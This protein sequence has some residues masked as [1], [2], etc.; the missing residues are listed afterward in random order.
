MKQGPPSS[1]DIP[2]VLIVD[3][4]IANLELL[5]G[6]LRERGINPRPVPNGRLALRSARVN[7]PDLILLDIDMPEMNGYEVCGHLKADTALKDIPVIFITAFSEVSDKVK[8]FSM[9]AVDYV[10][11]P[12]Q[13]DEVHARVE[14]HLRLRKL[15]NR[16]EWQNLHLAGLVREQVAEISIAQLATIVALAKLTEYR[17]DDTGYHIERTQAFCRI[18]AA[19]LRTDHRHAGGIDEA[20]VENIAVAAPLHDIGKVGISDNILLKPGKLTPEEF[21]IMKTHTLIGA[22]TLQ[23][24]QSKYEGNGFLN[25]GILIARSHHE[26][27]D[28]TGYPYGLA[29]EAIPLP[30]RVMALADVYDALRSR[31]RYKPPYSHRKSVEIILEGAGR[32]FD[33]EVVN[34]FRAAE[35]EFAAIRLEIEDGGQ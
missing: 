9:G 19:R 18:L 5:S 6:V 34:A 27:W 26:K 31:R 11:K 20:F 15:Q 33:P 3:D 1:M 10:T 25:M 24:A 23:A 2:S 30:A 7:P 29:G 8:A 21:E 12:F 14:T 4:V 22:N 17:D 16:L 28:G 35:G 32:H 13:L